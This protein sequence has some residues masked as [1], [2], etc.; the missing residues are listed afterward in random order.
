MQ[1]LNNVVIQNKEGLSFFNYRM[2]MLD[3][4]QE[5]PNIQRNIDELFEII[6]DMFADTGKKL[7][8]PKEI[9]V[10]SF[11]S[12]IVMSS[13]LNSCRPERNSCCLFY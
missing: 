1:E 11:F 7:L 8:Y 9:T 13:V 4:P 10:H 2:K 12:W 5:A 6:D 3:Y